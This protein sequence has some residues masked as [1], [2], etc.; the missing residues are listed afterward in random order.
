L[1]DG[2]GK[3]YHYLIDASAPSK[4]NVIA[5]NT[6]V[7]ASDA[8]WALNIQS[9]STGNV[10]FNNVL[11]N[12]NPAHG[13][14]DVS[15]D[16]LP[17]LVSDYN[18]VN[19]LFTPD[20]NTNDTLAQWQAITGQDK[21]SVVATPAQLFVNAAG[22]NYQLA[23]SSPAVDAGTASLGGQAA[24]TT[25]LSG[26]PRPSGAGYDIG[27]YELQ[28]STPTPTPTPMPTPTPGGPP[29]TW[30]N[31]GLGG[32][33]SLYAPSISP[34]DGN[35]LWLSSDMTTAFHSTDGGTGA[36]MFSTDKG[37]TWQTLH[38]FGH[39][40]VWVATDPNNPNRLY[41]SVVSS[42]AGGIYVT[43]DLQDGANSVWTQLAAPPR[44]QGHPL[45]LQVLK[46][47]TLVASYSGRRDSTGA[48]TASSGVFVSSDGG[49]TW[50]DRSAAGMQYWTQDVVIDPNDPTQNTWYAGDYGGWGGPAAG[51]GGLY[52]TTDRG[53]TWTRLFTSDGV[54][55][56]AISPTNANE[57]YVATEDNGL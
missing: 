29:T 10:V 40:V 56:V 15:S 25:D 44:T 22:N 38:T 52:K 1:E 14:I 23:A 27:A 57:M 36:V 48:F 3:L 24:P 5:N 54:S 13:S 45:D 19:N 12:N 32:G 11:Y 30:A 6:I 34:T 8:R 28:Q 41:A 46:D 55:S 47:G 2:G 7:M 53:Q 49:Q 31:K 20:D 17:G 9:G 18:D 33:G 39:P 35:N 4:N 37:A 42:T 50:Q 51:L 26:N 21:H 16:S 43:N